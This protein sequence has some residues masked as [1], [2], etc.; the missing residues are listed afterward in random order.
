MTKVS[1]ASNFLKVGLPLIYDDGNAWR[2]YGQ[3]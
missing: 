1:D 2:T 3:F